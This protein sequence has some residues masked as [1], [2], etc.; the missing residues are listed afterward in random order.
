MKP[1]PLTLRKKLALELW[2]QQDKILRQEHP[3]KQL[4]W[5][6]TL[7][8]DLKCRHCGSDCKM[9]P[10]S[11]DM[12]K[13]DFLRVL[14]GIAKK[15]DPHK[16]FVI[17]SGG[18]PLMRRDIE[19]C[20]R[21]IYEKGF[22]WGMVTN[23][24]HLTPE[25]WQGLLK[26]GIHSMTISLDGLEDD[27]NWMRGNNQSFQ[28]VSNAIDMLVATKGF[29]F[30][31]VTC[32]YH[33]NYKNLDEIKEFLISKGVKRWR[34]FTVFPVGRAALDPMMKLSNEEF[35]GVFDFIRATRKEGRIV[36]DYGCEGFL[37]NYEGE[38]RSRLFSCQ[39]GITVGSVMADGSIAACASIRSDYN[40]GNIYHDDFMEVWETRY[41]PYR[42][43]EWMRKDDCKDCK[44]FRYCQGNG[45]H[46]RDANG[47]LLFCHLQRLQQAH[48]QQ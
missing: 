14:D 16:V 4:F 31:I 8:C 13:E 38:A 7:R 47:R 1:T 3:L 30:D 21:A 12:P 15:V 11:K 40:Q 48:Q 6:C 43:R 25:R 27:H 46:L 19:D 2:R 37:G 23:A 44:Y 35:R 36:A 28:M 22:P 9:Q 42:N 45:M 39:A 41:A 32:V 26:A 10:E 17:V 18:E 20:G 24:L 5:E 29:V 33:R 34:L